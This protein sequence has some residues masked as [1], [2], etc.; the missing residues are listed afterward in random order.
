MLLM[1]PCPGLRKM[2]PH[3]EH[4]FLLPWEVAVLGKTACWLFSVQDWTGACALLFNYFFSLL[5]FFSF[6]K[7]IFIEV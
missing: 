7:K 2:F 4:S 1:C 6:L 3:E 5:D